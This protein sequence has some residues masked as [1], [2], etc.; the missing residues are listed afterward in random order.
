MLVPS[1]PIS[2]ASAW[3]QGEW[4]EESFFSFFP[5]SPTAHFLLADAHGI[6]LLPAEFRQM[7]KLAEQLH[8]P[9]I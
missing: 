4:G 2:V 9:L 5:L 8:I 7:W 1:F 6:L 3:L